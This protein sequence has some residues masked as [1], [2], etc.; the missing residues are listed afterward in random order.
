MFPQ[1]IIY[2]ELVLARSSFCA[3]NGPN[4]I[5]GALSW[6]FLAPLG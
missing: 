6:N 4:E 3:D 1:E 5:Q 2:V